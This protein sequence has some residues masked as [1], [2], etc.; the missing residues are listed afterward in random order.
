VLTG[1]EPRVVVYGPDF[2]QVQTISGSWQR[3]QALD[4]DSLGNVFVLDRASRTIDVRD[5]AGATLATVGPTLPGGLTLRDVEDIA[6]D[7]RGRLLVV[8][9]DISSVVVLE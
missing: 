6:V 5:R 2:Q 1:R 9:A 8:D 3:P 7:A 4:V